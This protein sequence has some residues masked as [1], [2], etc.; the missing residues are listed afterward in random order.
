MRTILREVASVVPTMPIYYYHLPAVTGVNCKFQFC[1]CMQVWKHFS[2]EVIFAK[3]Y[4]K[5]AKAAVVS[6]LQCLCPTWCKVL[7]SSSLPSKGW[8]SVGLTWWTLASV[9]ATGSRTGRFSTAWMRSA[10][11]LSILCFSCVTWKGSWD[12]AKKP[13]T[14]FPS[15]CQSNCLQLWLWEQTEGLEG[16]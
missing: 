12:F 6:P 8:S 4:R 16:Q 14:K 7:R 5:T 1:S 10:L 15:F 13:L 11:L 2:C 3:S 9:S